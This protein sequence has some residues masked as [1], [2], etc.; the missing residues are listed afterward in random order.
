MIVNFVFVMCRIVLRIRVVASI[1]VF[2]GRLDCY[3]LSRLKASLASRSKA[4]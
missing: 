3:L 1:L 2:M 4:T